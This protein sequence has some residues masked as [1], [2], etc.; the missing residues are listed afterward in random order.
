MNIPVTAANINGG[1][2]LHVVKKME[3]NY[4][5]GENCREYDK[6]SDFLDCAKSVIT[7]RISKGMNC[8]TPDMRYLLSNDQLQDPCKTLEER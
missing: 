1:T 4:K 2:D 5:K 8:S 3:E 7:E 6:Y